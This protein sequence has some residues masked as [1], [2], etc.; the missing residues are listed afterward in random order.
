MLCASVHKNFARYECLRVTVSGLI[1]PFLFLVYI[2]YF[3]DGDKLDLC[4]G[5]VK[6]MELILTEQ[7]THADKMQYAKTFPGPSFHTA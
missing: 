3:K 5:I 2:S 7:E 6:Q 4:A 1:I